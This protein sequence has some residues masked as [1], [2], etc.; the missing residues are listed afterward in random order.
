M[1]LAVDASVVVSALVDRGD[2][3][4]WAE[5]VL[6][7]DHLVAPDLLPVEVANVL[8]RAV[9]AGGLTRDAASLAHIELQACRSTSFPTTPW[10]RAY[11]N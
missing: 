5:E 9:L 10:P 1:S 11:G 6:V 4:R 2:T 7:A 3:G 8:R